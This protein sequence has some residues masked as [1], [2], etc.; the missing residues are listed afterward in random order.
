MGSTQSLLSFGSMHAVFN[1]VVS[2]SLTPIK[3]ILSFS[4][5]AQT[6]SV[7]IVVIPDLKTLPCQGGLPFAYTDKSGLGPDDFSDEKCS[8]KELRHMIGPYQ[9]LSISDRG[10]CPG[11]RPANKL[12]TGP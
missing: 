5:V 8:H 10:S 2:T 4:T 9:L 1:V 12:N 11:I 7:H 3:V 6:C